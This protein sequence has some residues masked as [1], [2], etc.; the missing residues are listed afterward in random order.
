LVIGLMTA[1]LFGVYWAVSAQEGNPLS[2]STSPAEK[3]DKKVAARFPHKTQPLKGKPKGDATLIVPAEVY[4]VPR[5]LGP[6]SPTHGYATEEKSGVVQAQAEA[7]PPKPDPGSSVL[8]PLPTLEVD[9]PAA[10]VVDPIRAL[11]TEPATKEVPAK[12]TPAPLPPLKSVASL[13]ESTLPPPVV[14]P[15]AKPTIPDKPTVPPPVI[16]DSKPT[17]SPV[18]TAEAK[19][20]KLPP[21][22]MPDKLPVPPAVVMPESKPTIP[23]PPVVMPEKLTLPPPAVILDSKPTP[24]EVLPEKKVTAT[25]PTVVLPA[26]AAQEPAPSEKSRAF[27]R[28]KPEVRETPVPDPRL[29]DQQRVIQ[30]AI[31]MGAGLSG[32]AHLQTPTV[33]VEKRGI[34]RL[35][36][37]QSE[38]YQIVV[39]NL[40]PGSAE[41]VHIEDELPSNV[42]VVSAEPMP[43]LQGNKAVWLISA[44][45]A[46]QEQTLKLTLRAE[47]DT[48]ATGRIRAQVSAASN[49]AITALRPR[50]DVAPMAIQLSGPS[51][52]GVGKPALFEIRVTNQSSQ[53]LTGIVLHGA[54]S[55]GLTSPAGNKIEGEVDATIAPGE[56]KTLKMPAEAIKPGRWTVAVKVTAQGGLEGSASADIEVATAATLQ[57][58][59]PPSTRLYMGRD[60]DLRIDV[61][62]HTGK[63]L[64]NVTVANKLPDGLD[65]VDANARGLYQANSR[66]VY[67]VVDQLPAGKTQ[68]LVVRVN[69]AKAGQHQNVVFAKADGVAELQSSGVVTLEGLSDLTLKVIERDN[70]LELGR[71]TEYEVR[72]QNTGNVP[73]SNVQL[74]VQLPAGLLL[75]SAQGKTRFTS[76]RNSLVFEPVLSLEARGELTFRVTAQAQAVGDQRIRFAVTSEQLR[77]PVEREIST[78]IYADRNP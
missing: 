77:T 13:P 42:K 57:L 78:R 28:I 54:L 58:L 37:D 53:A 74:Q 3:A 63:P 30:P 72:V 15:N 36:R 24:P 65:F 40:G 6:P 43:A 34:G 7:A 11:V 14:L 48:E 21:V 18:V 61:T 41:Q 32:L 26:M 73:A 69:G 59:Q 49:Q 66:I 12:K 4:D 71:E 23:P 25:P 5:P 64:R 10:S 39:R 22:V 75:K 50:L 45:S 20:T 56:T 44:I 52:V 35:Q 2:P 17:P 9:P 8:T 55:D 31:P 76:D 46:G 47:A 68:T 27:V 16:P 60:G 38:T 62:N 19:P 29:L 67:W 51:Q 70:I 33:T 1:A